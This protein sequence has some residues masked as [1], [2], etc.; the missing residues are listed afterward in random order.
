MWD[1][2]S[3]LI[4]YAEYDVATSASTGIPSFVAGTS[5]QDA[6]NAIAKLWNDLLNYGCGTGGVPIDNPSN[7]NAPPS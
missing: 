3:N 6:V 2:V 4:K 1:A 5:E 7:P